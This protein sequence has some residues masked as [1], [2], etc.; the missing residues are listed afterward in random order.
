MIEEVSDV[1]TIL[2]F[3]RM[4]FPSFVLQDNPFEKYLCYKLNGKIIGFIS[5]SIIYERAE[6]NYIAVDEPFR[7]QGIAQKL[8]NFVLADLKNNMVENF[9]LEVSI[10][11]NEAINFYLKNGFKIKAVRNNYYNGIDAYL[12]ALG[13]D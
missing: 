11:N 9:S 6:L 2:S 12:M 5:Y 8:L 4:Y 1:N 3:I 7:R 13:G 10:S